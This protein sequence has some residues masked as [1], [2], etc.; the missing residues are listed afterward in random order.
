MYAALR[1]QERSFDRE[2]QPD[3]RVAYRTKRGRTFYTGR[4]DATR[5][6][7]LSEPHRMIE[8]RAELAAWVPLRPTLR[9]IAGGKGK[10]G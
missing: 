2:P 5:R 3:Q 9:V 10:G 8:E 4:W 7:V 1:R 6:T